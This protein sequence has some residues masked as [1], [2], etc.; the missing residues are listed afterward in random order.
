[1]PQVELS[2]L[3]LQARHLEILQA[4]LK[5]H[6]P[7]AEVWA[8]GSRVTGASHE[9][10]DLDLVLRNPLDLTSDVGGWMELKEALQESALPMLVE[11]HLWPQLPE[12]FHPNIEAAHVVI[13]GASTGHADFVAQHKPAKS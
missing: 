13:Q 11:V 7:R 10:S 6:V 9:G 8:Y 12:T 2:R 3:H 5:R 4:L 1:M